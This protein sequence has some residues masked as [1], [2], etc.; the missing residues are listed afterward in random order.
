MKVSILN[1]VS[2]ALAALAVTSVAFSASDLHSRV[3]KLEKQMD[4]VGTDNAFGGYGAKTA[5][6]RPTKDNNNWFITVDVLY[7]K[8]D[9]SGTEFAY[10]ENNPSIQY[11]I[12]GRTKEIDFSWDWGF[13]AG[14]GYN[15]CFDSW[16]LYAEYTYFSNGSSK[17]TS[18]G[19]NSSV[20]PLR[21]GICNPSNGAVFNASRAKA[22]FDFDFN[23]IDLNLGRNYF[24]SHYL[25]FRPFFGAKTAWIDLQQTTRY[26]GGHSG[27]FCGVPV[28]ALGPNTL[29]IKEDSDFWGIGPEVGFNS[30]WH[31][32]KGFSFFADTIGAL[33]YG[34]FDVDHKEKYTAIDNTRIKLSGNVHKMI[35]TA[36]IFAGVAYDIFFDCDRQHFGFRVGY[37]GQY[38][39]RANQMLKID[40]AAPLKYERWS[41]DVSMH[42]LTV[43]FRWDF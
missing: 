38:W 12:K 23:S 30:K 3:E 37:D 11:P 15:F 9:V 8:P 4:Q 16:D 5:P 26:C 41:E 29:K 13:R 17:S 42:G 25:S 40:D 33:L 1:R 36:Q 2:L 43:D 6:A 27:S 34:F 28:L 35:P 10:T 31:L 18:G 21:G 19:C 22:Q 7:W 39:W 24:V 20:V 32:A 14:L